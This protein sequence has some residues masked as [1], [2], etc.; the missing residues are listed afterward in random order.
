[1]SFRF[2]AYCIAFVLSLVAGQW[3]FAGTINVPTGA[4]TIADAI[5]TA[6]NGDVINIDAGVYNESS[7]NLDGKAITIQGTLNSDGSLATTIDAQ[8]LDRVFVVES[9]EGSGTVIK[10]LVITGGHHL[11][12][13][14][15]LC[16]GS[17]PTITGCTISGN[18]ANY[19][20]GGIMCNE[21]CRPVISDC[22]ITANWSFFGG[23]IS[24]TKNSWFEII[25]SD[26]LSNSSYQGGGIHL[27]KSNANVTG[28]KI[29]GNQAS[30][31]GG[32][33]FSNE[34]HFSQFGGFFVKNSTIASNDAEKMGGG[35]YVNEG[36]STFTDCEIVGNLLTG[37]DHGGGGMYTNASYITMNNCNSMC[38]E[39]SGVGGGFLLDATNFNCAGGTISRNLAHSGGGIYCGNGGAATYQNVVISSNKALAE[40]TADGKGGGIYLGNSTNDFQNCMITGNTARGYDSLSGKGGGVYCS[41]A[42]GASYKNCILSGNTSPSEFGNFLGDGSGLYIAH[43]SPSNS[44]TLERVSICGNEVSPGGAQVF[45]PY[46]PILPVCI[47]DVC[48]CDTDDDGFDDDVDAFPLDSSLATDSDGDGI[49]DSIDQY[50]YDFNNDGSPDTCDYNGVLNDSGVVYGNDYANRVALVDLNDDGHLDA[51]IPRYDEGVA[52]YMN[53]GDGTFNQA[54]SIGTLDAVCIAVA[55]FNADGNLDVILGRDRSGDVWLGDGVGGF[56]DLSIPGLGD[57]DDMRDVAIGDFDRDGDQ[58]AVF[59][60]YAGVAYLFFNNGDAEFTLMKSFGDSYATKAIEVGDLT[61]DGYLDAVI[62]TEYLNDIYINDGNGFFEHEKAIGVGT[63]SEDVAIGDLDADGL[64]DI[65]LASSAFGPTLY[66]NDGSGNFS[67]TFPFGDS[68]GDSLE[69]RDMNGDGEV[70]VMMVMEGQNTPP[71]G[72][73]I[74]WIN[75]GRGVSFSQDQ[76]FVNNDN[77]YDDLSIG[78]LNGDGRMDVWLAAYGG[79]QVLLSASSSL[80]CDADGVVDSC[81][82]AVDPSLDPDVDGVINLCDE[83]D[84]GDGFGDNVDAFP[85]DGTEWYDSDGDGIGDNA[86]QYPNDSNN[87]GITDYCDANVPLVIADTEINQFAS[88]GSGDDEFG[89]SVAISGNHAVVGAH[90]DDDNGEKSGSAYI[91]VNNHNGSWSQQDKLTAGDA[92]SYDQFGYSVSIDGD[93]AVVSAIGNDSD[94][95]SAYIFVNN[96]N[97]SWSQQDKLLASDAAAGDLFGNS[98]SIDGDHVVVGARRNEGNSSDS[99]SAYIFVNN[100]NGSWSQQDKLIA[101]DGVGGDAFGWSVSI[102]GDHAVV[103]APYDDSK[104]GSAYIFV[105]NHNGSW[106][107]EAKLFAT[108][109]VPYDLFGHSVSIDGDHAVVSAYGNVGDG[110]VYIFVNNHDGS[111]SQQAELIANDATAYDYFGWSVSIA[112]DHALVGAY[113]EDGLTCKVWVFMNDGNGNWSQQETLVTVPDSLGDNNFFGYSVSIAGDHAVVGAWGNDGNSSYSGSAYFYRVARTD[114][115]SDG[116]IDDCD[117]D[118]DGDGVNDDVDAFPLD[119]TEWADSDGDGIGDNADQYPNDSN[120]NGI[121]DDCDANVPLVI[122]DTEIKQLASDGAYNDEFGNAVSISGDHAVVGAWKDDDNGTSSGSAYIFVNNHNGSWSQQDKLTADDAY[123][124][125]RFGFSVSIDGDYAVVGGYKNDDNGTSSGSAYIFVNNHNGSWSQQDKLL[126]SDAAA[127]DEFGYSVSIDGDYAV[128][129]AHEADTGSVY[130]FVNNH[131]GSW[132]QQDKLLASDGAYNDEFGN[133]VSI[134]GDHAVVGAWKGDDNGSNSGSAYIFVKN[135]NGSWSQQDKLLANDGAE[136]DEFGYSV[137]ISGDYAVVGAGGNDDN[138][139]GSGSAYIFVKN[140]NGSWSQQ[141]KLLANDGAQSEEFGRSVSI[142]GDHAVVGAYQDDDNGTSSGSAYIFVNNHN[143]SWSQ[144]DKLLADDGASD[145]FFGSS[146]SIAGDHAVVGAPYETSSIDDS[147]LGSAY[148]Y[149]VALTDTD[150]DGEID[151][152]DLDDDGDGVNDD[153]DAFPLDDT[154]WSDSD[155]DG[156]GDNADQ[157]PNDSNNDG[158]T[159]YCD[160]NVPLVIADTE[161]KQLSSDNS[162][163]DYFGWS[164]SISGDHAV[165]GARGNDGNN[166]DSGSAY[167]FVNNHNGSWSQQDKLTANDGVMGDHFGFSVSI[168]GDHV[169]VG[170]RFNDG[171]SSDSGSA[172]I[173]VNN[174]NGSWSQQ[175]K[176]TAN[177]GVGGDNFGYSV[178]I[179]GDHVV[180]GA[181]GIYGSSS[182]PG[183]AYIFV[184]NHNGSWSQQ[185]K[186]TANDGVGGDNFGYGVSIDGDHVVVGAP[187]DDSSSGSAYIFVNNHNGSWSQQDKFTANDGVGSDYFGGSVSIDGDYVVVGAYQNDGNSSQSGSAYIFVNNHNGSWSQQDKLTANDGAVD[188]YFGERVSIDGDHVVVGASSGGSTGSAYIFVNNHNGSWSQQDKLLPDDGVDWRGF[189]YSV[190]IDGDHMLVGANADTGNGSNSGSSYF[191]R[192][193][194]TDTDSDGEVDDCDLD[195]DNDGFNDD[196]DAFP[197]DNTEWAD[198]DGDGIGDNT[199]T[200]DDGDGIDDLCDPTQPDVFGTFARSVQWLEGSYG[201]D[202]GLALGDLDNDGDVD[203]LVCGGLSQV[204]ENDGAGYFTASGPGFNGATDE[205][206]TMLD[207]GDFNNDGFLDAWV[208][209]ELPIEDRGSR[210]LLGDGAGNFNQAGG[211]LLHEWASD[212]ALGDVDGDGDLD[213]VVGIHETSNVIWLNGGGYNSGL[214]DGLHSAEFT[215]SSHSLDTYQTYSVELHDLDNDGDLDIMEGTEWNGAIVWINQGAGQFL[216]MVALDV[217]RIRDIAIGDIDS[218]NDVDVLFGRYRGE[219]AVWR[220][221]GNAT[222]TDTGQLLGDNGI[223]HTS[224][225]TTLFDADGDGDLDAWITKSSGAPGAGHLWINDGVGQ[226]SPGAAFVRDYAFTKQVGFADFNGDNQIDAWVNSYGYGSSDEVWFNGVGDCNN[227]GV[228]DSC[229]IAHDPALDCDGNNLIDECEYLADAIRDCDLD[230]VLDVCEIA[231]DPSQDPDLDGLINECDLDDDGDG[232]DDIYDDFPLDYWETIDTDHDGIGDNADPDVDGDGWSNDCD[233]ETGTVFGTEVGIVPGSFED[234]SKFGYSVSLHDELTLVGAPSAGANGEVYIFS[235]NYNG[236]WV[237]QGTLATSDGSMSSEF[238]ASVS[239]MGDYAVVGA[240]SDDRNGPRSG[241]AYVFM[242]DGQGNWIEQQRL[243]PLDPAADFE[244]GYAVAMGEDYIFVGSPGRNHL[245]NRLTGIGAVYRFAKQGDGTWVQDNLIFTSEI[246]DHGDRFGKSIAYSNER[247]VVSMGEYGYSTNPEVAYIFKHVGSG[248]WIT[249]AKLTVGSNL[250]AESRCNSVAIDGDYAV[251]GVDIDFRSDNTAYVFRNDNGNWQMDGE[252]RG[253]DTVSYDYFGKAVAISGT[254][255]LVGAYYKHFE[256]IDQFYAGA[257]Y[258]FERTTAGSW[259]ER[260]KFIGSHVT[261]DDYFGY[262]V[263]LNE[264]QAIVGASGEECPDRSG[265]P[266]GCNSGAAYVYQ[267]SMPD[268]NNN[269]IS[270]YCE[271]ASD[272]LLDCDGDGGLDSCQITA[273]VSLD[274][275]GNGV[276]DSCEFD[277]GTAL[278]C[279]SNGIIDSCDIDSGASQDVNLDDIPDECQSGGGNIYT[280]PV[281][282]DTIQEA[283]DAA[284]DGDTIIVSDGIY[285]ETITI[286]GKSLVISGAGMDQTIISGQGL[287]QTV[288]TIEGDLASSTEIR[289]L[290]IAGGFSTDGGAMSIQLSSPTIEDVLFEGNWAANDG[291]A[292][293]CNDGSPSFIDCFFRNNHALGA[294]GGGLHAYGGGAPTLDGCWFESNSADAFGGGYAATFGAETDMVDCTFYL[295]TSY[296]AGGGIGLYDDDGL[297]RNVNCTSNGA[298][299]SGGGLYVHFGS[300]IVTDSRFA[301][302]SAYGGGGIGT[303]SG[304]VDIEGTRFCGN[305]GGPTTGN[306]IYGSGNCNVWDCDA[307]CRSDLNRDGMT[308]IPDLLQVVDNW[309]DCDMVG[310]PCPGDVDLS[311]DVSL[312]DMLEVIAKWG[313]CP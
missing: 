84:D 115:D 253:T 261:E 228:L 263:A 73:A 70:D 25:D 275:D 303:D 163:G 32:G 192:V 150:D 233:L 281:D 59:V 170:A 299:I 52:V 306:V 273:D 56:S 75:R 96:H 165:V 217:F 6:V 238:G 297:L 141:D 65:V 46:T 127:G 201:S 74:L 187:Y 83:D 155:G 77:H 40:S 121:P 49:E 137:S 184:N 162:M 287:M 17:S 243:E 39:S 301:S 293:F 175:D 179:D 239:I 307:P 67:P 296:T 190:S 45:G 268:C 140:D 27:S 254:R 53:N 265:R 199:D 118:D 48:S 97:G 171:N 290:A 203:A 133:A 8:Q 60:S 178:S 304:T 128:V 105:N 154:E 302:N 94:S 119:N 81:Q 295:N 20:G 158:I 120:N 173:F 43:S 276:L 3:T 198:S 220:N 207:L 7:L 247:L 88:D 28:C 159:D 266:G 168:D 298:H 54:Q 12:G 122:A 89:F 148:F 194:L 188:D 136:L 197:L 196:V 189:G 200:D 29:I 1:M 50:P 44:V 130:I 278:D 246:P 104:L 36:F 214:A 236:S 76:V 124:E 33:L 98:I 55:D 108:D 134:S 116:E 294:S 66:R 144:Q 216:A 90:K 280:V 256:E 93:Y 182:D 313:V 223:D 129:G 208:Y 15:I 114:T 169:V 16:V 112:G 131:N 160:A 57:I 61:G 14:G 47:S 111:W 283:I 269:L 113:P 145:D 18:H 224:A 71:Y 19:N 31:S 58:D 181:N 186:L 225:D 30:H 156:I 5:N 21:N 250:P 101:N 262:S 152:C 139:N 218:D 13:S 291:G 68:S 219:H 286:S 34:N 143:G 42:S 202:R 180:V 270:D 79:S 234:R 99:G 9:G 211:K 292:V 176:L 69:L 300:A 308:G 91:F 312:L 167:I 206:V 244:F 4:P 172:Y 264:Q 86:D 209:V 232:V 205:Y 106:S 103:G 138:G 41:D 284:A 285:T 235:S 251:L 132:S 310:M 22:T 191:Y 107:Q 229:D 78:D 142:S 72:K 212:I 274:C 51:L 204:W 10:D 135:D 102:S 258:L 272:S 146:V 23:G 2:S 35:V 252:V 183:S 82:I 241:S 222:F 11:T 193:A 248:N 157:Y 110:D 226:Y 257:A 161:F 195:D 126:A 64:L 242:N 123:A 63:G 185:D 240:P 24:A 117:L 277:N 177:D 80:D 249:E 210:V 62:T 230:Q 267:L 260:E 37:S 231:D 213:A 215:G 164:V 166:S 271:L 125:D 227:N 92:A 26:I 153:V 151:D 309:G 245:G 174:H 221:D 100:H 289:D 259:Y 288:I 255:I 282:F 149:R 87:D 85:L 109:G 38:N 147:K 95:G 305:E 279:N 311:R 237:Q